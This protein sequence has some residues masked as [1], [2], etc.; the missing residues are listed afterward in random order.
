M[1]LNPR[2]NVILGFIWASVPKPLN[3]YCSLFS[4][5]LK[6]FSAS[7]IDERKAPEASAISELRAVSPARKSVLSTPEAASKSA[8]RTPE[9]SSRTD[10][11]TY[12]ELKSGI[13]EALRV[14][15]T[16]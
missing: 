5:I 2:C 7:L 13:S 1:Y 12:S 9:A 11:F 8:R 14:L 16:G 4:V 10:R 15:N 6:T 3:S